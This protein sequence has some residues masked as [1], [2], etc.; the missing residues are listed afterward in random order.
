MKNNGLINEQAL[1][2]LKLAIVEDPNT[3]ERDLA[4]INELVDQLNQDLSKKKLETFRTTFYNKILSQIQ[5][6]GFPYFCLPVDT[7]LSEATP[8]RYDSL[9]VVNIKSWPYFIGIS[10]YHSE[11]KL[12]VSRL[13]NSSNKF[14]ELCTNV[15]F[16]EFLFENEFNENDATT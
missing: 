1:V 15:D 6:S 14:E 11:P 12:I 5:N 7:F 16:T 9:F 13:D 3:A 4:L 2:N 8:T 10:F